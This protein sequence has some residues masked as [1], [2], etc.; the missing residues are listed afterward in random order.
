MRR[1]IVVVLTCALAVAALS[2]GG[3][4]TPQQR[5]VF[6]SGAIFVNVDAYPRKDGKVVENLTKAD[7]EIFED[8]K[9]QAVE[10]FEFVRVEPNTPDEERRDPTSIADSESRGRRSAQPR[11]RRLSRHLQRHAVRIALRPTADHRVPLAN[12]RAEG[13]VWRDDAGAAGVGDHVR[14]AHGDARSGVAEVLELGRGRT[15]HDR[16]YAIRPKEDSMCVARTA[17]PL[18]VLSARMKRSAVSSRWWRGSATCATNARTS[19]SCPRAG[20]SIRARRWARRL[21]STRASQPSASDPGAGSAWAPT[22]T[23]QATAIGPGA[24]CR[25]RCSYGIDYDSRFRDLTSYATRMNVAFYPIDVGGLRTYNVPASAKPGMNPEAYREAIVARLNMMQDF[26]DGHRRPGHRQYERSD[27]RREKNLGRPVRVLPARLL[28]EQH[29]RGRQVPAHRREGQDV[30]RES[31]RP[32]RLSGPDGGDEE[33]RRRGGLEAR[34]R[35][36][37]GRS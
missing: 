18:S 15:R 10:E 9:P 27:G 36:D 31:Q 30:G 33:G 37:D 4:Q 34:P 24:T 5:P 17:R 22:P 20:A 1:R 12:D 29:R 6:R 3:A 32:S 35:R 13:S 25:E 23:C 11:V 14:A 19:C 26:A 8:G 21:R 28:L 16:S 2:A 7:F